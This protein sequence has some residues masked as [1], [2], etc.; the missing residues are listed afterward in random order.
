ETRTASSPP[1]RFSIRGTVV[2]IHFASIWFFGGK[3]DREKHRTDSSVC[4]FNLV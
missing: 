4:W 2:M 1:G 3:Q